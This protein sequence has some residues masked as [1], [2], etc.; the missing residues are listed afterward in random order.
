MNQNLKR[1]QNLKNLKIVKLYVNGL[2]F[3]ENILSNIME[4]NDNDEEIN[5][6]ID[7]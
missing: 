3:I 5:N 4:R 1:Q 7:L 2:S 6:R